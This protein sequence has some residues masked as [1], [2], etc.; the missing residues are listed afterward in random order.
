MLRVPVA[1]LALAL[2]GAATAVDA[3]ISE[4]AVECVDGA[5]ASLTPALVFPLPGAEKAGTPFA[6]GRFGA[7]RPG[8]HARGC[9]RGHCGVDLSAPDG[10]EVLAAKAGVVGQ[11]ERSARGLGG[12][13]V[14]VVHDDGTATWYMHLAT[15]RDGLARGDRVAAGQVLGTLGRSGVSTSPTHLHFALTVGKLGHERHVD[16]TRLLER[17]ALVPEPPAP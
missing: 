1:L 8:R 2:L 7:Y 10:T 5:L 12:R 11:I 9:G 17:A 3:P 15:V 4:I 16:A 13:Y 6:E 14:A